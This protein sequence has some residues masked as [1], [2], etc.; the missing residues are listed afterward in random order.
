MRPLLAHQHLA[1]E[2]LLQG[3]EDV[4]RGGSGGRSG[5]GL[6]DDMGLSKTG[7]VIEA[8]HIAR[9]F[10]PDLCMIVV[11]PLRVIDEWEREWEKD[12]GCKPDP[13]RVVLINYDKAW[14]EQ[15]A[16]GLHGMMRQFPTVLVV[17]E[18]HQAS[19]LE[20]RRFTGIEQLC[21]AAKFVWILT[22]TPVR[23][24]PESF[25]TIYRL[26]TG[27]E[28]TFE[29]FAEKFCYLQ[30]KRITGYRNLT[31]LEAVVKQYCLR[32]EVG[33]VLDSLP[34]L[35]EHTYTVKPSG[36]QRELYE[37]NRRGV[38][39]YIANLNDYDFEAQR[40]QVLAQINNLLLISA[41]P[42]LVDP[43]ADE[44]TTKLAML[45]EII[46]EAGEQKVLVWSRY[47]RICNIIAERCTRRGLDAVSM[48]GEQANSHNEAA[49]QQFLTDPAV[50]V[51]CLSL[52]AFSEGVNL[53]AATIAIYHDHYWDFAKFWQS[54]RRHWRGGQERPCGIYYLVGTPLEQYV[55]DTLNQKEAY[56]DA[57]TGKISPRAVLSKR[58]LR[59]VLKRSC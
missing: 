18:A 11:C 16:E 21:I 41:H 3:L 33:D 12:H 22:G 28:L 38:G 31:Q 23:N 42:I 43:E 56:Q 59:E 39:A 4:S 1:V 53:Q 26:I 9:A 47:P 24:R 25:F 36:Q 50:R 8:Y 35:T 44:Q 17:D 15:Y 10:I 55:L 57:V 29:Q 5:V 49:K 2:V 14:R 13:Q 7:S 19:G 34:L 48:H 40:N 58:K 32:R 46:D 27:A 45:D 52:G 20:S 30:H 37:T 51:A 6:F 54:R